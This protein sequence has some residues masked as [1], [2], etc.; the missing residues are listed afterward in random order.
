MLSQ[1]AR[2]SK[3]QRSKWITKYQQIETSSKFHEDIRTIL[4]QDDYWGR[5]S[6]YQEVPVSSIVETYPNNRHCVDWFIDELGCILEL[7]GQQHYNLVNFGNT[8]YGK[9]KKDFNNIKYRDNMKKTALEDAGYLYIEI[10]YKLANK[11]DAK[12]LKKL[13]FEKDRS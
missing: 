4:I 6:C 9:A 12:L 10:P 2:R 11:L 3:L 13:I 8:S 7:H 1:L 5:F